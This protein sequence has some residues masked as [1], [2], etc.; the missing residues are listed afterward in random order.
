MWYT[1]GYQ[2]PIGRMLL[3]ADEVGLTGAWFEGGKYFAAGLPAG[4]REGETEA[5][6]EAR[7]WLD[8]YFSGREP[9]FTPPVHMIGTPFQMEVWGLLLRI[10]YGQTVTYGSL[11]RA[12][13]HGR[14]AGKMSARAVGGAVG[15]NRLSIII[16]CHRV[17]GADGSLTGYAGGIGKKM[18]LLT[19]E[20]CAV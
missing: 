15:R 1:S 12:A 16:P 5:L 7:R 2:S 13:A 3:A 4:R 6:V 10:P 20:G 9:G 8:V 19:L 18:A 11:A 14:A 17:V